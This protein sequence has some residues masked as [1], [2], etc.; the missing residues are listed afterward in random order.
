MKANEPG[1]AAPA[2][3][4]ERADGTILWT[5]GTANLHLILPVP[6]TII[7][8]GDLSCVLTLR[9]VKTT[10]GGGVSADRNFKGKRFYV[11]PF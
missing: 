7:H 11:Y 10:K 1:S 9:L 4:I 3:F 5:Y 2:T 6:S 8:A